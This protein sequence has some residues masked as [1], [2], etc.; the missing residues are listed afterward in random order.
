MDP[1]AAA[2]QLLAVDD[3]VVGPR[4]QGEQFLVVRR[5]EVRT[6]GRG[7]GVVARGDPLVGGREERKVGHP[8]GAEETLGDQTEP[9]GEVEA[10]LSQ[11]GDDHLVGRVGDHEDHV[12]GLGGEALDD[13][14]LLPG[15]EELDDVRIEPPLD[16]P[17]PG[18]PLGPEARDDLFGIFVLQDIF[19]QPL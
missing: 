3:H 17:H 10:Q 1:N 7:E 8:E 19:A 12:A 4:A 11:G 9:P 6:V 15:A 16:D 2:A 18:H 14:P 5:I 13:H